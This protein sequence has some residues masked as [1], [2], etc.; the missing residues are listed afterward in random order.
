MKEWIG[1][2]SISSCHSRL[3]YEGVDKKAVHFILSQSSLIWRSG[4]ESSPFH[5][6][7]AVFDMKERTRKRSITSCP[8]S[9]LYE[10][11]DKKAVHLILSQ[12]SLYE[13]ADK[14]AVHFIL[15][16]PSLIWRSGQ[17]SD[18]F[19]PVTVVFDMKERIRK[20][21]I[22]S[23]HSRLWYEGVDKKANLFI[24]SRSSL[25]WRS[26][27]ESGPFHPVTVVFDMEKRTRSGLLHPVTVVFDKKERTRKW[28]ISS[29]QSS[30]IW[31]SGQE[32][33]LF[34]PVAVVFD[35]EERTRK[36]SISSCHSR[37][38]YKGVE[39]KEVHYILF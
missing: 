18:P 30:L 33:G 26:G 35:M 8:Q 32:S 39:K 28:S 11:A 16:Q 36:R 12:S 24:L 2:R 34:Y 13:G 14:K 27:Q 31:R 7:T 4:Q 37:L 38:W 3:W 6:V 20:R 29:C 17:E 5:L 15:S 23:C 22:S 9:S 21:P 19:L 1:K 10:G 25:I